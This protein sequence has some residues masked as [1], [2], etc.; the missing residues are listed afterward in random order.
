[1]ILHFWKSAINIQFVWLYKFREVVDMDL[2]ELLSL[3][4]T[5]VLI[6][7]NV[8]MIIDKIKDK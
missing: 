4:L 7:W 6:I 3:I 8:L 1:M 5:V 2:S